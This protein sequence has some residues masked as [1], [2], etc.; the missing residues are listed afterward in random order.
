[1][2]EG[3][4]YLDGHATTPVDPRVLER[5]LPFFTE[6]F[7]NAASRHH[8]FGWRAEEAACSA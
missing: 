6:V 2:S 3:P 1:M 5:M 8:R 7:G 4:V